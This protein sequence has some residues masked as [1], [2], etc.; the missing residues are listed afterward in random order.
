MIVTANMLVSLGNMVYPGALLRLGLLG[1]KYIVEG[2]K[3][4]VRGEIKGETIE[5]KE[6]VRTLANNYTSMKTGMEDLVT[7]Q[8]KLERHYKA[9]VARISKGCEEMKAGC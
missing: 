6:D 2:N 7:R 4:I 8:D 3:Y 1:N 5:V 9:T